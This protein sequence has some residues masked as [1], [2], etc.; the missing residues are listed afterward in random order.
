MLA[1]LS[2]P[3]PGPP[4]HRRVLRKAPRDLGVVI[5]QVVLGQEVQLE[6]GTYLGGEGGLGLVPGVIPEAPP[7][8]PG[9]DLMGVPVFASLTMLAHEALNLRLGGDY[10]LNGF[11]G[12]C[13]D[14]PVIRHAFLSTGRPTSSQPPTRLGHTGSTPY[15]GGLPEAGP[16]G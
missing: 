3:E 10:Q 16:G 1:L 12:D 7:H 11:G 4:G 5:G 9:H 14:G 6:S 2:R 13:H 15:P 8:F